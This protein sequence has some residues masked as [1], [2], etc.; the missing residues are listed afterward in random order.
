MKTAF[1]FR[2][3]LATGGEILTQPANFLP[4][5]APPPPA[6][7]GLFLPELGHLSGFSGVLRF[8]AENFSVA[9]P[10]LKGDLR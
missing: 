4:G 8:H 9:Q 6:R 7:D 2:S 10:L 5:D 1:E 3:R